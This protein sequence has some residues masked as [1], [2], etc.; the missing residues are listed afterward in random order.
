VQIVG[1]IVPALSP[2]VLGEHLST[3]DHYLYM[4]GGWYPDG[5]AALDARWPALARHSQLIAQRPAVRK[6]EA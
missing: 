6:V 1:L 4:L 3:A 2:Y 5:R